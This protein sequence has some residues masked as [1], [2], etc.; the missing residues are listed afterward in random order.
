MKTK[1][2]LKKK[3]SGGILNSHPNGLHQAK[4]QH[5]VEYD[6]MYDD[7]HNFFLVIDDVL[8]DEVSTAF[9]FVE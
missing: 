4:L 8:Y 5:D 6:F 9:K 3:E 7:E 2:K 1:A